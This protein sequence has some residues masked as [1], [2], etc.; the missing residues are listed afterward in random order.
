[1]A[2][3][4]L[5]SG[6]GNSGKTKSIRLFLENNKIFFPN[7]PHDI[8]LVLPIQKCGQ[9]WN[10]GVASGG[11]TLAIVKR[12]FNF[13]SQHQC[14]I[15]VCASKSRGSTIKYIQNKGTQLGNRMAPLISTN[16]IH[17]FNQAQAGSDN[18]RVVSEIDR[19]IP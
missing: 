13:F 7:T 5:V 2:K 4:I 3:I 1:M 10:V 11:D 12:N 8:L 18:V 19:N 15:I 6:A 9:T 14:D 17:P 16:K